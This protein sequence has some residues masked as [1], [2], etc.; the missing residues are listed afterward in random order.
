MAA[1]EIEH[2]SDPE[3]SKSRDADGKVMAQVEI[4]AES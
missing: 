4:L 1:E 2:P 3:L